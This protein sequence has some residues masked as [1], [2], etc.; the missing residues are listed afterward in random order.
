[1]RSDAVSD[2]SPTT[3]EP[4]ATSSLLTRS[5]AGALARLAVGLGAVAL[6][7]VAS[8]VAMFGFEALAL[9]ISWA[10]G[11]AVTGRGHELCIVAALL[12]LPFLWVSYR[13]ARH[14]RLR[15]SGSWLA[16][17]LFLM[18]VTVVVPRGVNTPG[19]FLAPI[20]TLLVAITFGAGPGL[21]VAML[22][23]S[24]MLVTAALEGEGLLFV[25]VYA[26]GTWGTA[27]P[28]AAEIL[29]TGLLGALAHTVVIDAMQVE[30]RQ[31]RQLTEVLER[32]KERELLLDHSLR[33][34]TIGGMA[35]LV[36]HQLRNRMQVIYGYATL[37]GRSSPEEKDRCLALISS[38][39]QD[40]R[41]LLQQLLDVAHPADG[42][43]QGVELGQFLRTIGEDV[44]H[45]L[46]SGIT[47]EIAVPAQPVPVELDPSG[48]EHAL[49]NLV[50]NAKQ[51]MPDGGRLELSLTSREAMACITVAD[52]GIGIPQE[53]LPLIFTPYFTT[54]P[55]GE[56]T[57]LGLAAVDRFVRMHGGRIDVESE[58]G[59]GT[60]F[61]V[62][63]V[64]TKAPPAAAT[65]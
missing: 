60:K 21:L 42:R 5:L 47:V 28:V 1:M 8:C 59:K 44:R 56:G 23:A 24:L 13:L 57:G 45:L 37:G 61:T 49:W 2:A 64:E 29:A 30:A 3:A 14:G 11:L 25:P 15:G 20:L 12:V 4:A 63:F 55:K 39:V 58:V 46:P 36:A 22:G 27:L 43:S 54:K 52:T 32:Q 40:T 48:L 65:A 26:P 41:V 7:Y 6:V 34:E 31:Q 9:R 51:A 62:S 18:I 35:G 10:G 33:T 17:G 53:H 16:V 38:A 19:W 50:I